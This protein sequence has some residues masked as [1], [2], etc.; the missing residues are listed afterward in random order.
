MGRFVVIQHQIN[1]VGGGAY[2]DDLEDGV[3]E[4]S[5]VVEGPDEVDVAC[6]VDHE[7]QEL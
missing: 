7:V 4:R 1:G 2:E 6:Q 5:R 3:V